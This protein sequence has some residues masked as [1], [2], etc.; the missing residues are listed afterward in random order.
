MDLA[1][2]GEG[3]F[4]TCGGGAGRRGDFITS[5]QVG[6]LFGAVLARMLDAVWHDL[7]EPSTFTVVEA[8][9]GSGTLARAIRAAQPHCLAALEYV[10]VEVSAKQCAMH[11]DWVTSVEMMPE[12]PVTGVVLANELLDNLPFRLFV[13][14]AGWREAYVISRPDGTFAE[15]LRS[16]ADI[17]DLKLPPV[18][19]HGARVP[20]Q[21]RAAAWAALARRKIARGKLVVIDYATPSSSSMA[22]RPW[23]D[24]LRTYREHQRGGHYLVDPGSQ[25]ITAEVA[26]DQLLVGDRDLWSVRTQ[27][28]F[29]QRWGIDDLVA[30]GRQIWSDHAARPTVA[31][32]TMR[33]RVR[34]AEALCD[35]A[36]LG[37]FIVLEIDVVGHQFETEFAPQ[38]ESSDLF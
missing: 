5:P 4:Y 19:V 26:I 14:D 9:A 7:D 30:E 38:N 12:E 1:L 34:E 27:R 2:Y 3:G 23:R 31:A 15:V 28:Q 36:G 10:A 13:M 24:W 17:D 18:R 37:A 35:P 33:S 32:L 20:A 16:A 11:P 22:L 8:G 25:D 29:L 6:P 21:Q